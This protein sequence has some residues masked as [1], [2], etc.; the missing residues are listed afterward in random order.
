MPGFY[1]KSFL[2]PS[3]YGHFLNILSQ[4]LGMNFHYCGCIFNLFLNI[5]VSKAK[6]LWIYYQVLNF[7]KLKQNCTCRSEI[8]SLSFGTIISKSCHSGTGVLGWG[9]GANRLQ[10]R[11]Y[12]R[13]LNSFKLLSVCH[14]LRPFTHSTFKIFT[15]SRSL[16][17]ARLL[18]LQYRVCQMFLLAFLA[19]KK[20][21]ADKI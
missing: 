8:S 14:I 11:L 15:R 13:M 16:G 2:I 7:L 12:I 17:K 21:K 4:N 5:V 10:F 20:R 3:H 19:F 1:A 9:V 18:I 6:K